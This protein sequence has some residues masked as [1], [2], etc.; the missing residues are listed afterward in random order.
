[1]QRRGIGGEGFTQ[2]GQ[3]QVLR[4]KGLAALQRVDGGAPDHLGGHLVALAEPEREH[5]RTAHAG[6]GDL[7]DQRAGKFGDGL[8]HGGSGQ[9]ECRL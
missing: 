4:I 1:M 6:I 5:V 7:A 2:F 9:R 8:A 3:A